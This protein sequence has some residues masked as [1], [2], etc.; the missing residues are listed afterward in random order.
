MKT[1][2]KIYMYEDVKTTI[3]CTFPNEALAFREII[4]FPNTIFF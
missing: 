1:K 3:K 2:K 4:N